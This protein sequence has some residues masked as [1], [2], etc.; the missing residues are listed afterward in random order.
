MLK[1]F[2]K[3]NAKEDPIK[4]HFVTTA[5]VVFTAGISASCSGCSSNSLTAQKLHMPCNSNSRIS[6]LTQNPVE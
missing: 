5:S 3:Q 4:C 2:A 1:N 6:D